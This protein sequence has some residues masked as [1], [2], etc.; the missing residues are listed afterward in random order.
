M[1]SESALTSARLVKRRRGRFIF[2]MTITLALLAVMATAAWIEARDSRLQ[3]HYFSEFARSISWEIQDGGNA[4]IWLPQSGPYSI[5]LGYSQ[6]SAIL[7]RL[8]AAGFEVSAR[9]R[10]SEGFRNITGHGYYPI[11]REKSQAGLT[12]LCLLYTS[13]CV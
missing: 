8:A 1:E 7:P 3:A 6:L 9:A 10:Q 4:E 11:Y 12:L 5:R 2:W 13:R